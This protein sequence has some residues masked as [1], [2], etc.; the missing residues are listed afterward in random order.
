M[1][2]NYQIPEGF[3]AKTDSFFVRAEV[4]WNGSTYAQTTIDLGAFVDAL[5]KS[6]LRIHNISVQ[7][8]DT[9]QLT[10]TANTDYAAKFQVTTQSQ[11]AIVKLSDK[12][13]VA[14]GTLCATGGANSET[15]MLSEHV[16]AAPQHWENGYLV[17]VEQMYLAVDENADFGLTTLSIVMECTVE[18]LSEKAA[19][20]LALS[21]Q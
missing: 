15:V 8:D 10:P 3:M 5:G 20:A 4:D 2:I 1:S 9:M 11:T 7:W 18:K 12:S 17:G 21:Q 16:D 19:M 6:V 14:S 13:V